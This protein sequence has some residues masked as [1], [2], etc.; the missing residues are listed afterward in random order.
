MTH[1]YVGLASLVPPSLLVTLV[2]GIVAPGGRV[3]VGFG[4]FT[5]IYCVAVHTLLILFMIVTGRILKAAMRSRPLGPQFLAELNAFFARKRAYPMALLASALTVATAVLGYGGEIGVPPWVHP[6]LGVVA[7]VVNP[8]AL[9]E[10]L[11]TLRANQT[12]VDRVA[13]ELDRLDAAAAAGEIE[14]PREVGPE[15]RVG[16]RA[17]WLIFAASA[18]LPYLYWGLIVWRGEFGRVPLGFLLLVAA[19]SLGCLVVALRSP[20]GAGSGQS[21]G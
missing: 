11:R 3:H 12:L 18:W 21:P 7:V 20:P 2:S 6:L 17:R 16:P 15:W 19:G 5:S 9:T 13:A 4:L 8:W 10:G 14:P 1:Y